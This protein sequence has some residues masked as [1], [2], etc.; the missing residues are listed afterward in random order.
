MLEQMSL[1]PKTKIF[2][3]DDFDQSLVRSNVFTYN[4]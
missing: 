1:N 3:K 4:I 2:Y